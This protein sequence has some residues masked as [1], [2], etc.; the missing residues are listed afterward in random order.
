MADLPEC[1]FDTWTLVEVEAAAASRASCR[2][3]PRRRRQVLGLRRKLRDAMNAAD[4]TVAG[5]LLREASF[6]TGG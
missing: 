2:S 4:A 5:D 1:P 3:A 6:A